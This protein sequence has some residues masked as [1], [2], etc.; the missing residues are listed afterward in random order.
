[1]TD[2]AEPVEIDM[3]DDWLKEDGPAALV[4]REYLAPV[5][6]R[7]AVI[8]P[9]TYAKPQR[10][11]DE[12]WPGYNIDVLR[13]GVNVCQVDSVGSQANRMEPIF[14]DEKYKHLVPQIIIKAGENEVN[15]LDAGHRAAD[16]IVR[17]SDLAPELEKA[18]QEY[19]NGSAQLLAKIAPTSLVFGAWDSRGTQVKL[20]RIVRSVIRAYNVRRIH[21]S[22]QYVPPLDY[23]GEGLLDKPEKEEQQVALSEQG[24]SHAPAAWTHGG[25]LVEGDIRR[26]T[27]VN[28]VALRALKCRNDGDSTIRLKRYILGLSLSAFTAPQS[29]ALREGCELVPAETKSPELKLVHAD[30]KREVRSLCAPT[31]L[32]YAELAAAAFVVGEDKEAHFNPK[33]A[34]AELAKSEKDR[35]ASRRGKGS[36]ATP[37][38]VEDKE[39]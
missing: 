25:V 12:D 7:E 24:L 28:L 11:R 34:K 36:K 8:F 4:L 15:L 22:A 6:G 37:E 13:E 33:Q 1:M 10:M 5:E 27:I 9:P 18:F 20:P 2:T 21:R 29:P 39:P 17:F 16:A 14:K 31:A 38:T 3:F 30:G 35:K 26:E 32:A 19:R 23:V